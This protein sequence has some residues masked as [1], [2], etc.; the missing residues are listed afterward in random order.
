[1]TCRRELIC[2]VISPVLLVLVTI[3]LFEGNDLFCIHV[4]LLSLKRLF[5]VSHL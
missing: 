3:F 5:L 2:R 4:K 1:M